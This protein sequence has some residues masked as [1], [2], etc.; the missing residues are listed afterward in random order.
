MSNDLSKN[1]ASHFVGSVDVNVDGSIDVNSPLVGRSIMDGLR[2]KFS[3]SDQM[4]E[5]DYL[6][7]RSRILLKKHFQLITLDEKEAI[8]INI[9]ELVST[10][11]MP[12]SAG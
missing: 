6:M 1:H 8:R 2:R 9:E 4:Q 11:Y 5:G 3:T 7:D 10:I 12:Q